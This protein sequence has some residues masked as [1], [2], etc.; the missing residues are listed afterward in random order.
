[1][2]G[3]GGHMRNREVDRT[4]VPKNEKRGLGTIL[5]LAI[6]GGAASDMPNVGVA[7]SLT[8]RRAER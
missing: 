6:G 7:V 3:G 8:G 4:Y 5:G 1:M 2:C